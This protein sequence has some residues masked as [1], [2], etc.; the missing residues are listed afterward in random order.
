MVVTDLE[1]AGVV[2]VELSFLFKD[3]DK[4]KGL[5]HA[6]FQ[7]LVLH[8]ILKLGNRDEGCMD[9][10]DVFSDIVLGT[11]ELV[12]LLFENLVLLLAYF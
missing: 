11:Q 4:A 8:G 3:G 6:H 12:V 5:E 2:V 7:V 10:L 1:E 9:C